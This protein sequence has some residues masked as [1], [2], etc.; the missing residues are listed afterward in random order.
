MLPGGTRKKLAA[1]RHVRFTTWGGGV[2]E[3]QKLGM[4]RAFDAKKSELDGIADTSRGSLFVSSVFHKA[5]VAVDEEGTEAAAAT[6]VVIGASATSVHVEQTFR[7]DATHPF[8]FVIR[9]V[10]RGRIL[11]RGRVTNPKA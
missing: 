6:G 9:D 1:L 3:L 5:F 10:K 8:V 2:G 11:F 4:R 7:F